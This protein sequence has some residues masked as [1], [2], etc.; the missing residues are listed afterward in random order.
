MYRMLC[1]LLATGCASAPVRLTKTADSA[2]PGQRYKSGG[3]ITLGPSLDIGPSNSTVA[4][5]LLAVGGL[6]TAIVVA[7]RDGP[8]DTLEAPKTPDDTPLWA[9]AR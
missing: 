5:V 4:F 3:P 1:F 2:G 6:V 7:G 8:E 9:R